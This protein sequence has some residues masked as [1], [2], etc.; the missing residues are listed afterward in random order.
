MGVTLS[1]YT[2]KKTAQRLAKLLRSETQ[3][4][5]FTLSRGKFLTPII[6]DK[7][8]KLSTEQEGVAPIKEEEAMK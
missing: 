2:D 7:F 1:F 5:G 6:N 4:L 8:E 3:R